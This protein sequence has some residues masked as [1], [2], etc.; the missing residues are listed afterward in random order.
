MDVSYNLH[1][2]REAF[3][4]TFGGECWIDD[5]ELDAYGIQIGDLS[6]SNIPSEVLKRLVVEAVNHLITNG[7]R[8]QIVPPNHQDVKTEFNAVA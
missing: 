2:D 1:N 4:G 3:T 8:F 5:L 6:V 7:H